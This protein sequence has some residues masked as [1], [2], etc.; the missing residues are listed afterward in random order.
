MSSHSGEFLLLLVIQLADFAETS[1]VIFWRRGDSITLK[2][3]TINK[4]YISL[5]DITMVYFKSTLRL[6][7]C[8]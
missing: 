7:S 8:L 1:P 4:Q 3:K 5:G 6:S 2:K